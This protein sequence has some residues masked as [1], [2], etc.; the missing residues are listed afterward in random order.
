MSGDLLSWLEFAEGCRAALTDIMF[1][2][3]WLWRVP[4]LEDVGT[5]DVSALNIIVTGPTSGIGTETAR[6]LV[7]RGANVFLACRDTNRGRKLRDKLK[8]EAVDGGV[9]DP[10][11]EV[12]KL[13]LSSLKSVRD[14]AAQ[15][16]K[17]GAE[18]L[19]V[20]I[21]NAGILEL[22]STTRATTVD[23]LE[24]HVG[25]N[26]V[27]PALLTLLMMPYLRKAGEMY[28]RGARV[29]NVSSVLHK[30]GSIYRD[31]PGLEQPGAWGWLKAYAVS[32]LMD[33]VYNVE[34]RRRVPESWNVHCMSLHPGNI[35]TGIIR[36][37]PRII[38]LLY[39]L[40][41]PMTNI[42]A[43]EGARAT[44]YCATSREAPAEAAMSG[45][46][47]YFSS[48]CAPEKPS[49]VALDEGVGQWLWDWT[50]KVAGA[51]ELVAATGLDK[52]C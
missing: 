50:L 15:W 32:K 2:K 28:K 14:F 17:K 11:I 25:T 3:L 21:N 51:A 39:K 27:G 44:V 47:G 16:E 8:A 46:G 48:Y 49:R 29:V 34:L 12:M 42:T 30:I 19:H 33:V 36:T 31:D 26:H 6:A 1:Q 52:R 43:S 22:G 38:Q 37:S 7:L 35:M 45:T 13:D 9:T 4:R 10:R 41:V 18:P 23:G 5:D 40:V 24:S 20:L